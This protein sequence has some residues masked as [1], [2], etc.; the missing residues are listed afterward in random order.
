M[1]ERPFVFQL[2]KAV[3]LGAVSLH[4]MQPYMIVLPVTALA[5]LCINVFITYCKS[6][7]C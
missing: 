5:E 1:H 6:C 3:L 4:M 7:S 2:N